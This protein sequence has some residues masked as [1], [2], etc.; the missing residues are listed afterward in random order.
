MSIVLLN[1][2]CKNIV[3]RRYEVPVYPDPSLGSLHSYLK[4]NNIESH[5]LDAKLARLNL[6][7][8]MDRLKYYRPETIGLTSFTHEIDHVA[9]T[10]SIIKKDLPGTRI[11]IG[12][13]HANALPE[14]VLSEYRIFDIALHGEGEVTL[15]ELLNNNFRN[16]NSVAGIA[17]RENGNI[18]L[19]PKRDYVDL[20]SIPPLDWTDFP[21][22]KS[23]PIF[24]SRGC[25]H[26]CI[27]CS[28]PLGSQVRFR[29]NDDIIKE[30][31]NTV[32]LFN[33]RMV[34][35]W[36]ENFCHNRD[37]IERLL[38][39]KKKN[40]IIKNVR[41]FCQSHISSLDYGLLKLMKESGCARIGI[42][43]ESGND[44]ILKKTGK[45]ITKNRIRRAMECLKKINI[46]VEGYFLLGLPDETKK[47]CLDTINFATE[48]NPKFPTFGI[49]VPYPGTE[50]YNMAIAGK[51]GYR[52]ISPNWADYNK[53]IGKAIELQELSRKE[54]ETLQ[55]RGY[56]TV[57]FRNFRILDILRFLFQYFY[58][59][60]GYLINHFRHF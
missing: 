34:Y 6:S 47:T 15:A 58:D 9:K 40:K 56:L 25:R 44:E 37:S 1:I 28:R 26:N 38:E 10:A 23:Y 59:I 51:G 50:I 46:P 32:R 16:L 55:A 14:R 2:P 54:L 17:Y 7:G 11:L 48:L 31:E 33:P 49:V 41:W 3:E 60:K 53:I 52:I 39:E 20:K 13:A 24:T 27:F 57:L 12:G 5:V 4:N 35:F 36:D 30:L 19:N 8:I 42:G 43:L 22:A 18:I 21:K 45:G 29:N